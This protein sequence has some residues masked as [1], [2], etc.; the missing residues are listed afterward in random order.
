VFDEEIL[1]M[2]TSISPGH[3]RLWS[4]MKVGSLR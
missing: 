1:T 3:P 4:Q 2:V